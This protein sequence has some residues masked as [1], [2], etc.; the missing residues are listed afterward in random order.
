LN[1]KQ[2]AGQQLEHEI[3]PSLTSMGQNFAFLLPAY[4]RKQSY[5]DDVKEAQAM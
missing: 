3:P 4:K 2:Q 1:S 5:A